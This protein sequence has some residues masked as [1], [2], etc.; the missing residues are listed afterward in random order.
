L[1]HKDNSALLTGMQGATGAQRHSRIDSDADMFGSQ[2]D[3]LMGDESYVD[4]DAHEVRNSKVKE[5]SKSDVE[6]RIQDC[7]VKME[8]ML[9]SMNS[10]FRSMQDE[11][12]T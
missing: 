2:R 10:F 4:Y 7:D 1:T 9:K 3:S 6:Q 8:T 12:L 5:K 11:K